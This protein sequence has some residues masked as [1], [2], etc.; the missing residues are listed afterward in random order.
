MLLSRELPTFQLPA[1]A[2]PRFRSNHARSGHDTGSGML[3]DFP[4]STGRATSAKLLR[5]SV[6][7]RRVWRDANSCVLRWGEITV[8]RREGEV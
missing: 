5:G 1:T 7:A 2:I 6:N 3:A 4:F 8:V